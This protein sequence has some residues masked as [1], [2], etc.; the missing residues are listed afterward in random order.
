MSL[1]GGKE[2]ERGREIEWGS[3]S[4]SLS[5]CVCVCKAEALSRSTDGIINL[6]CPSIG[7]KNKT[8]KSLI[9]FF[10]L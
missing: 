3:L 5:L 2:K 1:L 10:F 4:L 9:F 7:K 6:T 8:K